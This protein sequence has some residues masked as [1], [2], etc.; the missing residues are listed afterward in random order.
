MSYPCTY[1]TVI[2]FRCLTHPRRYFQSIKFNTPIVLVPVILPL[3][4]C[5]YIIHQIVLQ[6][7]C[8]HFLWGLTCQG[9]RGSGNRAGI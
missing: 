8:L 1:I 2:F 7:S 4:F 9:H 3:L 6:D 5:F